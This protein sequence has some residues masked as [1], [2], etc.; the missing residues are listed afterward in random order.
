M[1]F[2]IAAPKT[3]QPAPVPSAA[4]PLASAGS[5]LPL[6][7]DLDGTL[8][9][10]DTLIESVVQLVKQQPLLLFKLPFWLM[11]GRAAFKHEVASRTAF[12]A[13][14]LPLQQDLLAFLIA[15]K[16]SGRRIVLA[17]AAHAS[18][19]DAIAT[20][21]GLFDQVLASDAGRN[22]KG[23]EKLQAIREHVGQHFVY[24]G[25]S[26]ADLPVWQAADAAILVG[27][28][29]KV[30][31]LARGMTRIEREFPKP[32]TSLALW[33]R[34]M[35]VHQW[36]KN[37]LL[38]VPMVTGFVFSDLS[39]LAAI[40]LAFMAFS[41]AA[42][43][44][45]MVNDLWDLDSDRVHPRKRNRPFASGS[46]GIAPGLAVAAL[47]L[48]TALL[49][50]AQVSTAFLLILLLYLFMTSAY[51]WSLKTYVLIDV[52]MLSML[53]TLR[54]LA[55]AIAVQVTT[56]SWLLA[57]SVFIFFSLALVK[58]CS[59]LVMLGQSGR[60]AASGRD[61]RISDLVVLWPLGVGSSLS[62]IVVLG[63]FIS[64]PSTQAKYASGQL[65]WLLAIGMIYWSARLWIKTARGEMHDDPLVFAL[66]DFGSCVSIG[67]MI[68]VT[69]AA[70]FLVLA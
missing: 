29:K 16:A 46:I 24:A 21:L 40:A 67:L 38:L 30:A 60:T 19:A 31:N 56:S 25:D 26:R 52:L 9:P 4:A 1:N 8:T 62:A 42:S 14:S 28:S 13:D 66:K 17:T 44:T 61:Y 7:V 20:R 50:A 41:L 53:Y 32:R 37:L 43:A 10:T 15:E 33:M 12:A 6:V 47:A 3:R 51:S 63:L 70:H 58:R 22:L 48:A 11:R 59:E 64:A 36:A 69:L 68:C 2:S 54:I 55:G 45:Y 18:I 34:A 57:F 35:R 49:L 23:A 65:L 39:R 27:A 5:P